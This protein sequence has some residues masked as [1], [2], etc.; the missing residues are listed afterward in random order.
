MERMKRIVDGIRNLRP[1]PPV[2]LRVLELSR[3]A[4]VVP[5]DL[6]QVL[7]TDA[8][9]T[10]RILKMC[11]SAFYGF[12]RQVS[13][14]HEAGNRIGTGSL[15]SLVLTTCLGREFA[16]AGFR[17]RDLAR[18]LWERSVTNALSASFLAGVQGEVDRNTC[19]TAA[20][21]QNIGHLIT[22]TC[23]VDQ[24]P[25]IAEIREEGASLIEAE[26]EVL[27]IDHAQIGARLAERWEFPDLLVD[28]ILH[29][30][31]PQRARV[32]P[33][34]TAIGHLAEEITQALARGEGL[35]E[36]AFDLSQRSEHY[37]GIRLARLAELEAALLS[38][39][40]RARD[41]VQAA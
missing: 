12:Q 23:T 1:W 6:V 21:L 15:V 32:A 26:R 5:A 35:D 10:A 16:G 40:G 31:E 37:A 24:L 22:H 18:K 3:Q 14:L 9:L 36:I 34:V 19:Y 7:Q 33:V 29:H 2:A 38:E 8:A 13:S 17:D 30:H 28:S 39:L 25:E 27:G 41:L 4:D 11:N 20:L